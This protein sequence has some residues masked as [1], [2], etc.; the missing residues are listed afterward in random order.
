[1]T[2]FVQ[3]DAEALVH[4][5]PEAECRYACFDHRGVDKD[6]CHKSKLIFVVWYAHLPF[7]CLHITAFAWPIFS[8]PTKAA[9]RPG[10][11]SLLS[12]AVLFDCRSPDSAPVKQKVRKLSI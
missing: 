2:V 3:S 10:D 6:G 1:M 12:T 8:S 9:S 4:A 7:N 11:L 5:L